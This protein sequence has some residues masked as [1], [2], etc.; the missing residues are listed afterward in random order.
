MPSGPKAVLAKDWVATAPAPTAAHGTT[1]PT[2][3]NFDATATPIS[4]A[5]KSTATMEKVAMGGRMDGTFCLGFL[6]MVRSG[7]A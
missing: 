4:P 3:R 5:R 1:E 2:A 6:L 7:A